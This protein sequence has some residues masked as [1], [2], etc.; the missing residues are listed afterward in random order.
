MLTSAALPPEVRGLAIVSPSVGSQTVRI[1]DLPNGDN[2]VAVASSGTYMEVLFGDE[3]VN[4]IEWV[5]V[6]LRGF[7][8]GW[9]ARSLIT[10]LFERAVPTGGAPTQG[11]LP[12]PASPTAGQPNSTSPGPADT[13]VPT[14]TSTPNVPPP[15][16]TA[17]ATPGSLPI[18]TATPLPPTVT[19][20]P[21][22]I[23]L[24]TVPPP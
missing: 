17:T 18:D 9:I 20:V 12:P 14:G 21:T 5:E 1:R 11:P 16:N 2:L 8:N 10:F 13:A 24:P 4:G 7:R 6:R 15:A 22:R 3:E 19:T 23:P